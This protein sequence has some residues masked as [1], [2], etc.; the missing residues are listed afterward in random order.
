MA[1]ILSTDETREFQNF[2]DSFDQVDGGT[3]PQHAYNHSLGPVPQASHTI[4]EQVP[5][6][7]TSVTASWPMSNAAPIV[8]ANQPHPKFAT[9]IA[10]KRGPQYISSAMAAGPSLSAPPAAPYPNAA[11]LRSIDEDMLARMAAQAREL[12]EWMKARGSGADQGPPVQPPPLDPH[13]PYAPPPLPPSASSFRSPKRPRDESSSLPLYQSPPMDSR[14][15]MIYQERPPAIS[16]QPGVSDPLQAMREAEERAEFV[17]R[18][19]Q[20]N[21]TGPGVYSL[22]PMRDDEATAAGPSQE[23][24]ERQRYE[25]LQARQAAAVLQ[26]TQYQPLPMRR[27]AGKIRDK[28]AI[29]AARGPQLLQPANVSASSEPGVI[30]AVESLKS[31]LGDEWQNDES[32]AAYEPGQPAK[33][34]ASSVVRKKSVRATPASSRVKIPKAAAANV[35]TTAP[36]AGSGTVSPAVADE[37]A[38]GE[39]EQGWNPPPFATPSNIPP[40]NYRPPPKPKTRPTPTQPASSSVAAS[41]KDKS[42]DGAA[43]DK[44]ALLTTEQKKANHI[45][46]EQKRRAAIRQG[47]ESLCV[48][49]PTLRAAVEEF[50]ERVKRLNGTGS[51]GGSSTRG[52]KRKGSGLGAAGPLS[53]GIEIGGE[54]IDGRAGPKSEA[55]VLVKT[56]DYLREVLATR[57]QRLERLSQLYQLAA[58][59][60]IPASPG[61]RLW[62]EVWDEDDV[63]RWRATHGPSDK[64]AAEA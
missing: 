1:A 25:D 11:P 35:K 24:F 15:S 56:V 5:N 57:Q 21:G 50:E 41:K 48:V 34:K 54:K 20:A 46:S 4:Y 64:D 45:A 43:A 61:R 55:V 33:K 9:S 16:A 7:H 53:G 31:T 19:R 58:D 62:D 8:D 52:K 28:S 32:D 44:P 59:N 14:Q 60:G 22:Y 17:K 10:N 49:V 2:L 12:S 3:A 42:K 47:Y 38:E 51:G 37:D 13:Q 39:P 26:A 36:A 30:H 6:G 63:A 18:M 27:Q 23:D 29:A 40:S